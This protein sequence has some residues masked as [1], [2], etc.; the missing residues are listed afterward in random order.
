[1][2]IEYQLLIIFLVT[3]VNDL[4]WPP[5]FGRQIESVS[6]KIND[7]SKLSSID[8][9]HNFIEKY[10]KDFAK[11]M[12]AHKFGLFKVMYCF[13][14]V[15]YCISDCFTIWWIVEYMHMEFKQGTTFLSKM[16]TLMFNPT[17]VFH[18]EAHC[19]YA[20]CAPTGKTII[21][22]DTM[23]YLYINT[24]LAIGCQ[25]ILW[26]AIVTL[27]F[28]ISYGIP[29]LYFTLRNANQVAFFDV[30]LGDTAKLMKENYTNNETFVLLMLSRNV[31]PAM[32]DDFLQKYHMY[33]I[34]NAGKRSAS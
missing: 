33:K 21:Y 4:W 6:K 14:N 3:V 12:H 30:A 28:Q 32:F 29:M 11:R 27:M 8:E 18:Y 7:A 13:R 5:L 9:C 20:W 2:L 19:E 16:N 22:A 1:M 15:A 31:D 24:A 10:A 25:I 26:S 23:C 34:I 17:T